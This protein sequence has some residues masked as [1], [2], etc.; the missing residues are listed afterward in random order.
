ML[1]RTAS[2]VSDKTKSCK[3]KRSTSFGRFDIRN[4]SPQAKPEENGTT[5]HTEN[6]ETL[7]PN[8]SAG[9]GKKMKAIS[10]TMCRKMGK[11]H[12]KSFFEEGEDIDKDPEAETESC[13]PAENNPAKTSNSLESLYSGQ[14]SSSGVTSESNGSGQRDSLRLEEDGSYQGQFSGRA[15][16]HTDFVPS[17][18]DTDSLKLKVGDIISIISKPPMGIWIGMLNN[19]VGN[20]KFIY[21]DMLVEKEEEEEEAPKIRQQKLS[22]R[23]RPKTLLELLE[24]LNLEEYASALL[25]NGYQTVE[26]LLHLQE[27]HLIELN[28]HDP[29]DRRKIL[30]AAECCYTGDEVKETEE[31]RSSHSQQEEDSDC[32]RDSGCFIPS[33]CTESK[34][35]TERLT[36]AV[37]S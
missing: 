10:L 30:A 35:D 1:Q 13:P 7:D 14:S 34:E 28:V 27:K 32:P 37:D 11:K 9:L 17:P 24:R 15:R 6:C 20:F 25:L 3:P 31:Q 5:V 2:N 4:H 19:K 29:E 21:V 26:D 23:P 16:V 36:E 18:Y 8:K 12:A 33:E 22:K